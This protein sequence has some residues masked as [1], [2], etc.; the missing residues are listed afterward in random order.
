MFEANAKGECTFV[1]KPYCDFVG[2]DKEDILNNGWVNAVY[3]DDRQMI[4]TEWTSSIQQKRDFFH[5]FRIIDKS[6]NIVNVY[7]KANIVHGPMNEIIGYIG[8]IEIDN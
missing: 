2:K 1:T 8:V 6:G 7:G 5:K 3:E 4:W